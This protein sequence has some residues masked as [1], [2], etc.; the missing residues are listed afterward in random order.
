[1]KV[2][3]YSTSILA[4][5]DRVGLAQLLYLPIN[6]SVIRLACK[7]SKP[8][9]IFLSEVLKMEQHPDSIRNDTDSKTMTRLI[10]INTRDSDFVILCNAI[11]TAC[12][13]ISRSVRKAGIANL[14]ESSVQHLHYH[15]NILDDCNSIRH[16]NAVPSLNIIYLGKHRFMTALVL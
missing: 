6:R 3:R 15:G 9:R 13:L 8:N 14:C 4:C 12:K 11:Q 7:D 16:A 2:S 5:S 10:M 1:M